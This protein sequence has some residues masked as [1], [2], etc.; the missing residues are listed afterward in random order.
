[1]LYEVITILH[2]A[3]LDVGNEVGIGNALRARCGRPEIIEDGHQ[4]DRDDHPQKNIFRHV[5]QSRLPH[6]LYRRLTAWTTPEDIVL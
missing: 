2:A 1:M 4:D 6:H 3:A 5:I